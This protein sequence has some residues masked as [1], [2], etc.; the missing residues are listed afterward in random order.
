MVRSSVFICGP[1][2]RDSFTVIFLT[3]PVCSDNKIFHSL[4]K[5][6]WKKKKKIIASNTGHYEQKLKFGSV[7]FIWQIYC[8]QINLVSFLLKT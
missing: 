7:D 5:P 2:T 6:A 4:N 8:I 3:E 1:G